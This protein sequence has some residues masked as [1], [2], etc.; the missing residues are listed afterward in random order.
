MLT[1]V[2]CM[3]KVSAPNQ[4]PVGAVLEKHDVMWIDDEV[5]CGFGRT[6]NWFG[7]ETFNMQP[8]SVSMAKQL[9]GGYVPLSAVA[10]NKEMAEAIEAE[11]S[12]HP[13]LG[14]GFT[15]GGH[16]LGCAV[17]VKTLEIYQKRDILGH[18]R[19]VA[20]LFQTHVRR[21]ADH[22]LVGEARG[23]GLL[24]A[25]ELCPNKATRATF[26]TPGK[27]GKYMA[28]ELLKH[29][30]ILRAIGDTLA[31]CPPMV[32]SE[33]EIEQLFA[34]IETALDATHAWAKAEGLMG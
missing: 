4:L 26:A 2:G 27:V 9:T 30:V 8:T 18:V 17:G 16:P 6:G 20:P 12:R 7:A 23:V 14:H 19:R 13:S 25:L 1:L 24:G 34:P 28:D 15:Y 29:G 10:M 32:I 5:I 3:L 22:P 11:S 33:D 31:F 21:Y